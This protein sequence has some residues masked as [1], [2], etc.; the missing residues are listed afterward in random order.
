MRYLDS[1]AIVKLIL[2]EAETRVLSVYLSDGVP[3]ASCAV[4]TTEVVR[5]VGSYGRDAIARAQASLRSIEMIAI[6]DLL[7]NVASELKPWKLRS[8]DALHLATALAIGDRLE[9]V[10]TYDRRMADAAR[11][12]GMA[13]ESPGAPG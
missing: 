12:L 7:L 6:D 13:V 4:A 8:L 5:A 10:V 1:S 9:A 3:Q 11:T 2:V